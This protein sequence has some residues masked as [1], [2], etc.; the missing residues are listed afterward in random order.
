MRPLHNRLQDAR[1]RLGIPWDV[2]ERDYLLSWVLAGISKVDAL[3]DPLVFKG[4]TALRKCYFGDYRFSEDLDFS[5]VGNVPTGEPME[6]AIRQAC[7]IAVQLVDE[8]APVEIT[9]ERY[10]ERELHPGGQEAFAIRAR[11]PWQRQ[12]QTRVMVEMAL[13]E[14]VLKPVQR[15]K[16]I[17]DYGEPLEVLVPVYSLEEIVA[18]KLRAILQ[19]FAKLQERGWSRSRARDYYDIWRVLGSFRDQLDR[20]DFP[21]FLREKC[22]TRGVTFTGPGDFFQDTML[23]YVEKTWMQWLGPLVPGLPD[24]KTVIAELRPQIRTLVSR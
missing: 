15:R 12:P 14:K 24:F 21:A 11:L 20:S 23:A 5:A 3:R 6:K 1:S 16:I 13:D 7:E 4:G 17:H 2:L 9:C 10:E 18:E 8:Y 19:H 22:A